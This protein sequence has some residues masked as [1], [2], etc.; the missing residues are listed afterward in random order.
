MQKARPP[1]TQTIGVRRVALAG[2]VLYPLGCYVLPAIATQSNSAAGLY[3]S[4]I[5]LGGFGFYCIYPQIPPLL[6][7][8][9][10][11]DR[12]GLAV[13]IYFAGFGSGV[14]F[15]SRVMQAPPS[16]GAEVP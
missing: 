8:R 7:T 14:I 16:S 13:S 12:K 6:S 3:A 9:W 10:F 1:T 5:G 4:M 15:A 2:S 11:A